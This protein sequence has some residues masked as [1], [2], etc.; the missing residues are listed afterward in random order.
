MLDRTQ[1][2]ELNEA[3][4]TIFR[5]LVEFNFRVGTYRTVG[6]R[7]SKTGSSPVEDINLIVPLHRNKSI[8]NTEEIIESE[9]KE[10]H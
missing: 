5:S 1:I 7:I 6:Y 9:V 8:T 3:Q 4:D 2:I 10:Y